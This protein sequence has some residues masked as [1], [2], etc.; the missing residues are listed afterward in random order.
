MASTSPRVRGLSF[1][2]PLPSGQR[3]RER[4]GEA[5]LSVLIA[6][7]VSGRGARS[8][9]E[10]LAGRQPRQVDIDRLEAVVR[11]WGAQLPSPFVTQPGAPRAVELRSLD[12]LH[13]DQLLRAIPELVE[14]LELGRAPS[15][16]ASAEG[17][18]APP[19]AGRGAHPP[20]PAK[21][22][23]MAEDPRETL[24]R[25]L[26]APAAA[27]GSPPAAAPPP[28]S[29]VD[30][31][32]FIRAIVAGAPSSVAP[33]P[34]DP[35]VLAATTAELGARLRVLLGDAHFRALEASWRSIDDLCRRCPDP[36]RVRFSVLDASFA[37]L[38]ADAAGV[39]QLVARHQPQLLLV[40]H[41][42]AATERELRALGALLETCHARGVT[43]L[44]GARPELAGCASFAERSDPE[45]DERPLPPDAR[46]A[47]DAVQAQRHAGARLL[48]ALPRVLLRQPYGAAGEPLE[49]LPFEEL[50]GRGSHEAFCWG[51]GAYLVAHVLGLVALDPLG[52]RH[53]DGGVDVREL[54]VVHL[55]GDDGTAIKPCAESW[56]SERAVGRLRAAGFAV[57][58]GLRD[59]DRV[60]V[61][62]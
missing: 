26:G 29:P 35:A 13:P 36:D 10:P 3:Q 6:A 19:D 12:D 61:H 2:V 16:G 32:G 56:L 42:F 62:V 31:A 46:A 47:W 50:L 1:S 18:A 51:N 30:V 40:D 25:L 14:V 39:A 22:S 9:E 48:L 5:G 37:E 57:L 43:L 44:A 27:A 24:A 8:V 4:E 11:S 7:D 54:P 28:A 59:S 34:A 49:R 55:D 41:H 21:P 53:P 38:A 45:E 15:S 20:A 58:Q 17:H 60:R 52:A 33:A 23:E